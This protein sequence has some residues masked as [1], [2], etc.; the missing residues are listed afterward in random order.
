LI[1]YY[2][3]CD[4]QK[5]LSVCIQK[6][7]KLKP[8]KVLRYGLDIA[9]C[10]KVLM[11]TIYIVQS[12]RVASSFY[13]F[14]KKKKRRDSNAHVCMVANNVSRCCCCRG[15]TYLHQCKPDPIIHC[16]LKPK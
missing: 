16:D 6:K 11:P 13:I 1:L 7:G 9:R 12:T 3:F 15:M 2:Y 14:R 8:Q 10:S 4:T 5:D